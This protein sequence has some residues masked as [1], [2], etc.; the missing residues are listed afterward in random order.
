M[1]QLST[2][3]PVLLPGD[4]ICRSETLIEGG[5]GVRFVVRVGEWI[6][7]A[8]VVRHQG[9]ARGFLNRCAHKLVELDWEPGQFFDAD[10]RHL[11]CATHGALYDPANGMCVAGPCRGGRIPSVSLRE[12]DGFVW[13]AESAEPVIK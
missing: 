6:E 4:R 2:A 3:D 8:F 11:V 9:V 5:A 10:R 13:L 1:V 7:A 12:H